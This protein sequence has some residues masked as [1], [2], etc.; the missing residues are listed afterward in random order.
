MR[1]QEVQA[2]KL[3]GTAGHCSTCGVFPTAKV[4]DFVQVHGARWLNVWHLWGSRYRVMP[5][6]PSTPPTITSANGNS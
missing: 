3:L 5:S 4:F 6:Y 2:S 1:E